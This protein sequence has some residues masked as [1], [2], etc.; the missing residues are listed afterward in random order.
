MAPFSLRRG[1]LEL[2]LERRQSK[3]APTGSRLVIEIRTGASRRSGSSQSASRTGRQMDGLTGRQ[4]TNGA[5]KHL[6][7]D[8]IIELSIHPLGSAPCVLYDAA[9]DFFIHC[10]AQSTA[11]AFMKEDERES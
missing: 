1:L 11:G 2:E 9:L 5:M 7:R 10:G 3:V 6:W 4:A 8:E